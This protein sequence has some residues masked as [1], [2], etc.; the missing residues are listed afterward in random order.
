MKINK[1]VVS[2][3]FSGVATIALLGFMCFVLFAMGYYF[4]VKF[5]KPG[6]PLFKDI[7]PMQYFGIMLC[8]LALLPFLQYFFIGF[9]LE[10]GQSVFS[11]LFESE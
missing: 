6:T 1:G 9:L 8:I 2:G 11:S 3:I 5:N 4:I 7:Q 10:A